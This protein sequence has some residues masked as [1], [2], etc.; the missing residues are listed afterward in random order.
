MV[1]TIPDQ[2]QKKA[3]LAYSREP[4]ATDAIAIL[5]ISSASKSSAILEKSRELD[6]RNQAIA[7]ILLQRA[8]EREN[9]PQMLELIDTFAR[10]NPAATKD[11]IG[12][13][14]A[15]LT[16]PRSYAVIEQALAS[17]PPWEEAFWRKIPS[18]GELEPFYN[19]RMRERTPQTAV[20]ADIALLRAL[21]RHS[22]FKEAFSFQALRANQMNA[23]DPQELE[24]Q[25]TNGG[26]VSADRR[27]DGTVA[28]YIQ[29]GAGGELGRQ[30]VHMAP[31]SYVVAAKVED[32]RGTGELAL[33]LICAA[34]EK[35]ANA[36]AF[37]LD[38]HS[39]QLDTRTSTCRYWWL[40]LKGSAWDSSVPFQ[41]DITLPEI[42]LRQ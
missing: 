22:R 25:F 42:A 17:D 13:L 16:D 41:A 24:W 27:Q 19:L 39:I 6:K 21:V 36:Q 34:E 11:L 8:A 35:S 29:P 33:E 37:P 15:T 18:E 28:I 38:G 3:A 4:L 20:E 10:I 30:L 32:R 23:R 2:A 7:A 31:A 9:T 12:A 5:G 40:V 14:S 1:L 26:Q